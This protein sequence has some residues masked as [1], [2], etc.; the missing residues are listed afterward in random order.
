MQ[1]N[2][3]RNTRNNKQNKQKL[4][5]IKASFQLADFIRIAHIFT[6]LDSY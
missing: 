4:H 3:N 2:L 1:A 6:R 5:F